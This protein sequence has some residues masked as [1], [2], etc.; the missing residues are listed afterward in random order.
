[1]LNRRLSLASLSKAYYRVFGV[2]EVLCDNLHHLVH[3][4]NEVYP[5]LWRWAALRGLKRY[6]AKT[7][8]IADRRHGNSA[9][10]SLV[11]HVLGS[12]AAVIQSTSCKLSYYPVFRIF[13]A[14]TLNQ[15]RQIRAIV[16]AGIPR[17]PI[18]SMVPP[19][20]PRPRPLILA[21]LTP[22]AATM[23]VITSVVLSPTP[24]VE[25][26]STLMPGTV[27]YTHL[28]VYKR[29]TYN[30][31]V[32]QQAKKLGKQLGQLEAAGFAGAAFMDKDEVKIFA[33]Q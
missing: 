16:H 2:Y 17:L 18:L 9:F 3:S 32:L 10:V 25:C 14:H 26:L 33:Q 13:V 30:V 8:G 6:T 4:R 28:D 31:T 29:Q 23:G 1:M 19:V 21:I 24:P 15:F 7:S 22:Q 20:W 11:E 27:S 12:K 5:F